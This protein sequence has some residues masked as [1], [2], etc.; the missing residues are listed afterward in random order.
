MTAMMV[1]PEIVRVAFRR[2]IGRSLRLCLGV[3][4]AIISGFDGTCFRWCLA[5]VLALRRLTSS[6]LGL[7]RSSKAA[8]ISFMAS[9]FDVSIQV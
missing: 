7:G 1:T 4:A 5:A 3:N 8:M 2:R 6:W 9:E